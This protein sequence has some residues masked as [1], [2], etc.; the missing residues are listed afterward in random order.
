M[1]DFNDHCW[2]DVV[3]EE[4]LE[5]YAAYRRETYVGP[6]PAVLAID[7]Y[8]NAY[9]GGNI[10]VREANRGHPGSCGEN[11]WKARAGDLY[12]APCRHRRREVD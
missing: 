6:A 3:D 4:I 5:I 12:H 9:G 11:A 2:K 10:P 8:R 1:T 7:L